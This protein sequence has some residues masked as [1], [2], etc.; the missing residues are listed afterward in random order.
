MNNIIEADFTDMEKKLQCY[1][2]KG[3]VAGGAEVIEE[4][5]ISV[6]ADASLIKSLKKIGAHGGSF[7]AVDCSTRTLKRANNWGVY[8][9]RPAYAIVKKRAVDWDFEERICTAVGDAHSRS[10]YLKDIRIELESQMALKLLHNKDD[11]YYDHANGRSYYDHTNGRSNYLL[12][13]GGGYFGGERKFRVSLYEKCEKEGISLLA[14]SKNSPSLHDEKGRDFIATVQ[15]MARYDLWV[16]H[17][18]RKA[19]KD[20]SLYGDIAVV[21]LCAE[22]SHVFRCDV[23]DYLTRQDICELLS[24]LTSVSED[25]R[26]IGYPISLYLAHEF[27]GPSD[28]MLLSYYDQIEEKL[29]A[30]GLLETLRREEL[31]CSFAD[32]IHGVK[33]AFNWEWWNDQF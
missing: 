8:L 3:R 13:D 26:C 24:P 15:N 33:H 12:L 9:M 4:P 20:R 28:S 5:M 10:N 27:S 32:E 22:S 30:A 11:L 7:T 25:P 23:M 18:V 14:I 6:R 19:D 1:A 2:D 31:S 29:G 16:Y 17:P 21:K